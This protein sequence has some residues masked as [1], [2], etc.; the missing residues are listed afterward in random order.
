MGRFFFFVNLTSARQLRKFVPR[1]ARGT[2]LRL[3]DCA[4]RG[5]KGGINPTS[6]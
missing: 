6:S 1:A 5:P 3:L 4:P 2:N